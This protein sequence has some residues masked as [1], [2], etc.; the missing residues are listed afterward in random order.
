MTSEATAMSKPVSRGDG[1]PPAAEPD[2]DVAQGAVVDVHD[3]PP[4]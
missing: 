1:R 2:D 3:A 4:E